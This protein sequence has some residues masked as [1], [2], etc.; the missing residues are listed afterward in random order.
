MTVDKLPCKISVKKLTTTY[1]SGKTLKVYLKDSKTNKYLKGIKIKLKVY[2]GKKYK[3]YTYATD[4]NGL[5][6]FSSSKLAVGNHKIIVYS[7]DGNIKLSKVTTSLNIKK[8]TA[9]MTYP[10]SV[11]KT[12]KIKITIK[13]KASGKAIA[14]NKFK[15]KVFT[16]KKSK[17]YNLKTDSKGIIKVPTKKLKNG[18][19]KITVELKNKNYSIYKKFTVKIKK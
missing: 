1:K 8:A 5:I 12:S 14:K 6:K 2:T 11:K 10:K 18:G 7:T 16:G 4:K 19:H 9:K 15:V 3:I 13:N 17:I